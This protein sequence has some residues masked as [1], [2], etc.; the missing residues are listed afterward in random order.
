M[1]LHPEDLSDAVYNTVID[2]WQCARVSY[3]GLIFWEDGALHIIPLHGTWGDPL[4]KRIMPG[5]LALNHVGNS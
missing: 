3:N 5:W 4:L 1:E 2:D